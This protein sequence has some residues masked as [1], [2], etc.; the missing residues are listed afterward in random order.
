MPSGNGDKEEKLYKLRHSTAHVM[1]EAVLDMFPEGKLAFGPPIENGF[2]YDFDL[3]RALTPQDLKAIEKR[4]HK[5]VNKDHPFERR[6]WDPDEG[7]AMLQIVHDV[8]PGAALAFKTGF[9]SAENSAASIQE[10]AAADCDIIVDDI[11]YITEPFYQ[12]GL[13]AQAV[14]D[15]SDLGVIYVSAAGNYGTNSYQS[16]FSE[17]ATPPPGLLPGVAHDFDP[18]FNDDIYQRILLPPGKYTVALQWDDKFYSL[19]QMEGAEYDLDIYLVSDGG[20]V[21]YARNSNNIG[22]DPL[23]VMDFEIMGDGPIFTNIVV[24]KAG[25]P[26]GPVNFKYIFFRSAGLEIQEYP[27]NNSTLVGQANAES[28]I[29]VGAVLY[30][31][32]PA[33][34]LNIP[35]PASFSSRGGMIIDGVNRFKPNIMAPNGRPGGSR[36]LRYGWIAQFFWYFGS[37]SS[38]SWCCSSIT[39]SKVEI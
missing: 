13:V 32:T 23:E 30:S 2:Y 26:P 36:R 14:E 12:D 27:S 39:G 3:P 7:R 38:C 37:S 17:S 18:S 20:M 25:G 24:A 31:N 6:E 16:D 35:T 8:A 29:A 4:M 15:V 5:S 1:A 21:Q 10:L 11:S 28:A 9:L 22:L 33:Y 19:G 34:G